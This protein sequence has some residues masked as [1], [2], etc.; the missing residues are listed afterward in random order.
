MAKYVLD[1]ETKKSLLGLSPF[2]I[3]ETVEFTPEF[4]KIPKLAIPEKMWPTFKIRPF[5]RPEREAVRRIIVD[6]TTDPKS[7]AHVKVIEWARKITIGWEN[8]IDI[9]TGEEISYKADKD[10]GADKELFET[11][12]ESLISALL[13]KSIQMSGLVNVERAGLGY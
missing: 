1:E 4:Y 6:L 9:A 7:A 13:Y 8:L 12:T 2:S 5:A 11:L 10:G 3:D